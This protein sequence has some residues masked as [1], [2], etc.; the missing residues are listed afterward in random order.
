MK[1]QTAANAKSLTIREFESLKDNVNIPT[2]E[3]CKS[4]NKDLKTILQRQINHVKADEEMIT[5]AGEPKLSNR[6]LL[7]GPA[8]VGKSYF[9]KIFAKSLDADYMEVMYSDFNSMWIGE[10]V[11]N[12]KCIFEEILKKAKNN[13][14]KKFVVAFNEID[15]LVQPADKISRTPKGTHYLAKIEERSVFLNYLELLKEKTPNVTIIGTTNITP[16]NNGLDRASMSRFQN[17]VEV[18]YPEKDCLYEAIKM[19]L[20]KIPGSAQFIKDNDENLK[21]LAER[22]AERR[23]SFRNL[24]YVINDAKAYHLDEMT[25]GRKSGFAFEYLE[26]A[27]K[28]LKYSDGELEA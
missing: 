22:M 19:N 18:P 10:G 20:G 5:E 25:E 7:Y 6:L 15:T 1:G 4:I 9:A 14:N 23:F 24:E 26:K 13:P 11:D 3:N 12:L 27:E 8:G 21:N 16:K 2:I 17:L 28:N